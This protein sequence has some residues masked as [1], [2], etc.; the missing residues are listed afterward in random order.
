MTGTITPE[1]LLPFSTSSFNASS[2]AVISTSANQKMRLQVF[3]PL[4]VY[5]VI[6]DFTGSLNV[7]VL[8]TFT[9][10]TFTNHQDSRKTNKI[11]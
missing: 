3:L 2:T 1:N 7:K 10:F 5:L 11:K 8:F 6:G 9:A 4:L